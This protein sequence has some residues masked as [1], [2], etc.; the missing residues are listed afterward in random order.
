MGAVTILHFSL[1]FLIFMISSNEMPQLSLSNEIL[2]LLLQVIILVRIMAMISMEARVLVLIALVRIT[3]HLLWP[4]QG[5]II[6][7]LHE[8]LIEWGI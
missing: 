2:N 8:H 4:L 3:C 5:R 6:L 1:Q 7:D